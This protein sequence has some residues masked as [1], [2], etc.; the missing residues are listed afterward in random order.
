MIMPASPLPPH[1]Y[2]VDDGPPTSRS[3]CRSRRGLLVTPAQ[4][5]WVTLAKCRRLKGG[6]TKNVHSHKRISTARYS[7]CIR[8]FSHG[9]ERSNGKRS[10][11]P[12]TR[13]GRRQQNFEMAAQPRFD[14]SSWP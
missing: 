12:F 11:P 2:G 5:Y 3:Q 7:I 10:K 1:A 8:S 14:W 4:N 6:L 13:S 9:G